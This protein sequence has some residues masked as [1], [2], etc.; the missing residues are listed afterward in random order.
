M[1]NWKH[2]KKVATG[3][4]PKMRSKDICV[5]VKEKRN[6]ELKIA[7]VN[8]WR[9]SSFSIDKPRTDDMIIADLYEKEVFV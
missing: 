4:H 8:S 7:Q 3:F 5:V 2:T 6:N 9:F 1:E